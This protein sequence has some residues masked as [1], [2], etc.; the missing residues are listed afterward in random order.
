MAARA[1]G[2]RPRPDPARPRVASVTES[3]EEELVLDEDEL[4]AL[5]AAALLCAGLTEV[6]ESHP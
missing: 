5:I 4:E 3:V 2:P 1:D 6:W